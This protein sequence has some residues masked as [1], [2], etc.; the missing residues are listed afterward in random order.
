[1]TSCISGLRRAVTRGA[2]FVGPSWGVLGARCL[3]PSRVTPRLSWGFG[4]CSKSV[5]PSVSDGDGDVNGDPSNDVAADADGRMPG[6]SWR[7]GD[8]DNQ[9]MTDFSGK[10]NP[11]GPDPGISTPA[12]INLS[13]NPKTITVPF[14][15]PPLN[16]NG[17]TTMIAQGGGSTNVPNLP[18]PQ[19][20]NF[21]KKIKL[22]NSQFT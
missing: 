13:A 19:G 15:L 10:N 4:A 8:G 1:M 22:Y 18:G 7:G 16:N 11:I 21:L 17:G 2:L 20:S 9:F 3:T 12:D 14:P 6:T 5:S